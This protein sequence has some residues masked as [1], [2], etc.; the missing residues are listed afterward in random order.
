MG[1]LELFLS[2]LSQLSCDSDCVSYLSSVQ[3]FFGQVI[4][5]I[6]DVLN[7]CPKL[8]IKGLQ[9]GCEVPPDFLP[10][11]FSEIVIMKCK[12]YPRLECFVDY[13]QLAHFLSRQLYNP[14]V[15]AQFPKIL[16]LQGYVQVPTRFDVRMRIPSWYSSARRKTETRAFLLRSFMSRSSRNTSA[17][18]KSTTILV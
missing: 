8:M 14:L 2:I 17:S 5:V 15:V 16:L 1:V 7:I 9:A 10:L 6:N 13:S 3:D 11:D 18:S 12:L 4:N